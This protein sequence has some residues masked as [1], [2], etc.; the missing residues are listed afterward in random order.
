MILKTASGKTHVI[1]SDSTEYVFIRRYAADEITEAALFVSALSDEEL[2]D[3]SLT[4][5][6]GEKTYHN[7]HMANMNLKFDGDRYRAEY[8][9][10]G[11]NS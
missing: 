6:H 8:Y 7:G 3:F 10:T 4:D 11:K 1:G 2:V 9:I 5:L